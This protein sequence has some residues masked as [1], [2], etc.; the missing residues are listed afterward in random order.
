MRTFKH[1]LSHDRLLSCNMGQL[2]PIGLVQVLPGD[3]FRHSISAF[4]RVSPMLAPILARCDVRIHSFYRPT[5]CVWD[6]F[7]DFI[8]NGSNNNNPDFPNSPRPTITLATADH[9]VSTMADYLGLPPFTGN[10]TV[11]AIPFRMYNDT[12]NYR[13]RD[14]QLQLEATVDRGNGNDTTTEVEIR[15]VAWEKDRFTAARP[16]PQYG[17]AVELPLTG[18]APVLG[19]GKTNSTFAGA[20]GTF[21]ESDQS[22]S[23]YAG[24]TT[25]DPVGANSTYAVEQN[26]NAT[27][28]PHIRA[29]LDQITGG[30]TMEDVREAAAIQQHKERKNR[31]GGRY[32]ELIRSY[33]VRC[34]DASLNEP[35]YLGGG[36]ARLQF[37]E[38]LQ[39][40]PYDIGGPDESAVGN[41]LGHG[42]GGVKSR[43]Y[44]RYFEEWG[45][46]MSFLSVRPKTTYT[47]GIA[48]HWNLE[49]YLDYWHPEF[50]FIGQ[51]AIQKREVYAESAVPTATWGYTDPYDELRQEESYVSGEFRTS[52]DYWHM[53]R[54]FASEPSLNSSFV[55]CAPTNRVYADQTAHQLR[56]SV[57]HNLQA[58]RL[59]A[60][61]GKPGMKI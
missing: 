16:E 23:L 49:T 19:I 54:I 59:V 37:S 38:V 20:A 7:K 22:T 50:Q 41:L 21:R 31:T 24:Y 40:A 47:Q 61:R 58:R 60:P 51:Q 32:P 25:I 1:N 35:Q 34:S 3:I 52:L 27:T 46:V 39:T 2:I 8:T 36:R 12:W 5:R 45:Y 10:L 56:V 55:Q 6:G 4:I 33:G 44:I 48:K 42:I 17:T 28:Y 9:A 53:A 30:P 29:D 14:E 18:D 11:S 57:F 13:F 26:P 15:D 43:P